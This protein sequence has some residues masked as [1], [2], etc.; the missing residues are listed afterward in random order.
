MN[1]HSIS[2]RST[3]LKVSVA[4]ATYNGAQ[5][6]EQQLTSILGQDVVPDEIIICDDASTDDTQGIIEAIASKYKDLICQVYN[7]VNIGYTRNFEKAIALATGDV[8]FFSDQD[9]VWFNN[10]IR[11]VYQLFEQNPN[12]AGISHDGR[13]VDQDL[14]WY[15]TTKSNQIER[16]Y[17]ADH[18]TITGALSA[19]RKRYLDIFLPIP[20]GVNGHDTWLTYLFSQFPNRW[21]HTDLCLQD[22]RRHASNTSEWIVNSLRPVDKLQVFR[23]QVNTSAALDYD[24]R[25]LMNDVLRS[26]LC[27]EKGVVDLFTDEEIFDV[28]GYLSNELDAI[29]TRTTIVGQG[30]RIN[31]SMAALS[32]W[33]RGGYRFFNGSKSLAR[34]LLR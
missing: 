13:L 8:I 7:D 5:Y 29:N 22:V 32:F 4:I 26:R 34:D 21:L 30:S 28:L 11:L 33:A 19:I 25:L 18:R 2:V 27:E 9:D 16:G 17:G 24:D 6:F 3:P 15:G 23:T 31:R 10:K 20:V 12:I 14:R 1:R